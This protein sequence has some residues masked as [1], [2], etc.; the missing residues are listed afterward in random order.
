MSKFTPEQAAKGK[1]AFIKLMTDPEKTKDWDAAT[2]RGAA[3][4]LA[5]LEEV[6]AEVAE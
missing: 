4:I 5:Q 6:L 3:T 2:W 1:A